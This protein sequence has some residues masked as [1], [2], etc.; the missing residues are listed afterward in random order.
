MNID[1]QFAAVH[2]KLDLL[3]QKIDTAEQKIVERMR[4]MQTEISRAFE[5]RQE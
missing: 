3:Q 2:A 5:S 4:E 1:E